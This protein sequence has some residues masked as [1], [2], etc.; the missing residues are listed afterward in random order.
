MMQLVKYKHWNS[1]IYI[2]VFLTYSYMVNLG[3]F[4]I[5]PTPYFTEFQITK[6]PQQRKTLQEYKF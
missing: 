6:V 5:Y 4:K 3:Y 1:L 2:S